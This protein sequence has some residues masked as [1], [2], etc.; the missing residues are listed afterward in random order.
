MYKI[1]RV[2]IIT[3]VSF[4]AFVSL[5]VVDVVVENIIVDTQISNF[6]E[7]GVFK[8]VIGNIHLY[9]VEVEGLTEP[10]IT[11]DLRGYPESTNRGDIFIHKESEI[12][13]VPYSAAFISYFFG[14]HAGIILNESKTIEVNGAM[15]NPA[16]NVVDTCYNDIFYGGTSRDTLGLRVRAPQD[17]IDKAVDFAYAEVGKPYNFTF[18]LNR[19][20]SYYCT[21]LLSRAFGKEAGLNYNLDKD[22]I[23]TSCND[24]ILSEDTNIIYYMFYVGSEKHLYYAV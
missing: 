3:I 16:L 20:N 13:M 23:A 7:K 2:I 6:I 4:F 12:N 14:G 21:D 10:S 8:E 19:K 11:F 22:G 5:L 15:S 9:E 1:L 17:D 24:L 18:V